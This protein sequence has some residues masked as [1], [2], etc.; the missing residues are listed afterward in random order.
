M[1]KPTDLHYFA[2]SFL[3]WIADADKDKCIKRLVKI[4]NSSGIKPVGPWEYNLWQVPGEVS[5]TN[6]QIQ[7]YAPIVDGAEF[8]GKFTHS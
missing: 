4:D 5:S 6:Y 8:L 3:N 7:N 2:S 1:V